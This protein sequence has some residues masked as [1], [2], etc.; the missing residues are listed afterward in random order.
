M[1]ETFLEKIRPCPAMS[2]AGPSIIETARLKDEG[3]ETSVR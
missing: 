2:G 3:I 1:D